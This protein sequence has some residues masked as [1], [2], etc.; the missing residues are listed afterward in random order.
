MTDKKYYEGRDFRKLQKEWYKKAESTGFYDIEGGVEGHLLKG[1]SSTVSLKSL[2]NKAGVDHGLKGD[3]APREFDD[4][5]D[6][7][8]ADLQFNTGAKARYYHH[9][10][11]LT[12]QAFRE[13]ELPDAVCY[14]WQLHA[15]GWGERPI[16]SE[17]ELPRSLIR[18]HIAQLR[19][20]IHLRI[21][22]EHR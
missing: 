12:C 17:L 14:A 16:A 18:K 1:K 22:N 5:A 10:A 6:G 9:A 8:N 2:A 3:K 4:V 7:E 19:H 21:D 15:E 11:L 20:N 13:G